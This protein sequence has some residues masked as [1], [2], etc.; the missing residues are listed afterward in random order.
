ML[1][2]NPAN[3]QAKLMRADLLSQA[4][5]YQEALWELGQTLVFHPEIDQAGDAVVAIVQEGKLP[6][7]TVLLALDHAH[8]IA[9]QPEAVRNLVLQLSKWA[10]QEAVEQWLAN[11]PRLDE[12]E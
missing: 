9:R 12:G 5:E 11:H 8:A 6:V 1:V 10:N 7:S 4:G 2:D 3:P